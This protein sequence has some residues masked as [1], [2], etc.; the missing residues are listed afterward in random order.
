M[1]HLI[2]ILILFQL[3]FATAKLCDGISWHWFGVLMP[4]WFL[5]VI[6][7]SAFALIDEPEGE[8]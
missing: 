6:L 7:L 8:E 2:Y 1:P 5:L 3:V 4:L